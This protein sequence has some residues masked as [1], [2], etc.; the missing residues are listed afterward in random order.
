MDGDEAS[1]SSKSEALPWQARPE[2]LVS[3]SATASE[4][5]WAL[6]AGD[7]GFDPLGMTRIGWGLNEGETE[8]GRLDRVYAYR[9]AELKH[10]RLAMLAVVGWPVAELFDGRLSDRLGLDNELVRPDA[11]GIGMAPSVLN[12][13]L[14]QVSV[15]FWLG[16]VVVGGLVET[17]GFERLTEATRISKV[18]IPGDFGFDPLGL[19]PTDGGDEVKFDEYSKAFDM[20]EALARANTSGGEEAAPPPSSSGEE[21]QVEE[22]QGGGSSYSDRVSPALKRARRE[23]LTQEITHA[24]TAMLAIVGFVAQEFVTRVPVVEETPQF[25]I[26]DQDELQAIG[27]LEQITEASFGVVGAIAKALVESAATGSH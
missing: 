23:R 2:G 6:T 26:P 15:A 24:R 3:L 10:G 13:G 22:A 21:A 9:E 11:A 8:E 18:R 7:F 14:G 17:L 25:F 4:Y 1:A 27:E 12:G 20:A 16:V 5:E 19:W